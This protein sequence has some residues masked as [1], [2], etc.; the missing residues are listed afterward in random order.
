V[1]TRKRSGGGLTWYIQY[2]YRGVVEREKVGRDTDGVT[3]R[4]AEKALASRMGDIARGRF[5]I[6]QVRTYPRFRKVLDKYLE[7]SKTNK[8]SSDRDIVSA[9]HLRSFFGNTKIDDITQLTI[10]RYKSKRKKEIQAMKKNHG[11]DE[12]D[13]SFTSINRELALLKHL[14]NILIRNGKSDKNPVKGIK[15]FPERRR[16]RYLS[17]GEITTLLEACEK[18]KNKSLKSIVLVAL[19]TAARLMEILSLRVTDLDFNNSYIYFEHTK[20]GDR[21]EVPMSNYL[22]VVLKGHLKNHRHEYLFCNDDGI[23]YKSIKTSFNRAVKDAGI[24]GFRFHDLRHTCLSHLA[25]KGTPIRTLQALG[26]FKSLSMVMRYTHLSG[27]H[28]KEA[29]NTLEYLFQNKHDT[30]TFLIQADFGEAC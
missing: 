26:R 10:E 16:E 14:F 19:N 4:F 25:M 27:T 20:N 9:N 28:K 8:K 13:I 15:M 21:G 5:D 24:K 18:S 2:Y 1:F 29:V 17:E 6:A 3:K 7:M 12:R 22:K 30:S 11:K 23:P